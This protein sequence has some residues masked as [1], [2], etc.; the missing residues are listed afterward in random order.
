MIWLYMTKQPYRNLSVCE[1]E[2]R[3]NVHFLEEWTEDFNLLFNEKKTK[4]MVITTE[5]MSRAHDL[6]NVIPS[7]T[8]KGQT[9]K[10]VRT[11][12][13]LGTWLNENLKWT[14]HIKELVSPCHKVLSILRIIRDMAPQQ[15]KKQLVESL[16]I[17][18]LDY[19]NIVCY[20]NCRR[21]TYRRNFN[22]FK[23]RLQ[24]LWGTITPPSKASLRW[25]PGFALRI[26]YRA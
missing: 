3:S 4:Q 25:F 26:S 7:L 16:I 21:H 1:G 11:F 6:S 19:N 8:V 15:V 13:L 24:A 17:S 18:K 23:T 12:K 20:P 14:D 2:M 22:G 10:R 5:Q 9:L